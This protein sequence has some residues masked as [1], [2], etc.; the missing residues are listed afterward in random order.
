MAV[1][2]E[3]LERFEQEAECAC[4]HGGSKRGVQRSVFSGQLETPQDKSAYARSGY[5]VTRRQGVGGQMPETGAAK[6][7]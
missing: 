1:G 3:E 7:L 5:G 6:P 4:A 2:E